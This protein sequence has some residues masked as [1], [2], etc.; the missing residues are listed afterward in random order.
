MLTTHTLISINAPAPYGCAKCV[1][2]NDNTKSDKEQISIAEE[3][4]F[5]KIREM[6]LDGPDIIFLNSSNDPTKS[7]FRTKQRFFRYWLV[8]FYP[9]AWAVYSNDPKAVESRTECEIIYMT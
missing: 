3:K 2:E 8:A 4:M 9:G 1:L 5:Q 7:I 6:N